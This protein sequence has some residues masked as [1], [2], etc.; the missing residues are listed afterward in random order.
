MYAIMK[1]RIENGGY[2]LADVQHRIK[3]LYALGSF[4]DLQMEELL[5]LAQ[6]GANSEAERP[7]TLA[8]IRDLAGRVDKLEDQMRAMQSDD[9]SEPADP[10]A[11]VEYPE[12]QAWNGVSDDYQKGSVVRHDGKLWISVYDGQNVWQPGTVSFWEEFVL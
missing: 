2:K 4:D 7:E 1:Q 11:P 12:W 3:K 10:G 8:M 9:E 6:N 5:M